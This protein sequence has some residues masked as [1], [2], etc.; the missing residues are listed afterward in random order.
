MQLLFR[1]FQ[2]HRL[3]LLSLI[4]LTASIARGQTTGSLADEIHKL[5]A[6]RKLGQMRVGVQVVCLQD[7]PL[8]ICE[9][10]ADQPFKPASNQKL[11]TTSAAMALLPEDFKF[12]T[13]LAHRGDDLVVIGS[14]D[15]AIGDPKLAR[16]AHE[17]ITALFH[18]WADKIRSAGISRITG[19]LVFDDFIFEQEHI[20]PSWEQQFQS[21]MQRWYVAPV[22]GLN[23]NDNCVDVL[24]RPG[25]SIGAD[26]EVTLI[27]NTPYIQLS[28]SCKTAEKGEPL[29]RRTLNDTV[30]VIVSR[31]IAKS[32]NP[33]SPISLTVGDPGL[34]FAST[35][36]TVL[37][38]KGI[39][40]DGE[41]RRERVRL[42]DGSIP[43][44]L[45]IIARHEQTLPDLFLRSNR[46]SQNLF[47]E[48]LLKAVGAYVGADATARLGSYDN[49]QKVV[50][51]FL[52][53]LALSDEGCVID[54]GSGLSHSNRVTPAVLTGLL[55][56]MDRHP[57]RDEWLSN[58]ATPGGEGT[59]RRRLKELNGMMFAKT[60]HISGVSTL[61]G[62][63]YG[64]DNRRYAF[65]VLCNDTN[66][67][68]GMSAHAIQ[69]AI[70]RKLATWDGPLS[71]RR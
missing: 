30:N 36:R 61:T 33:T 43:D 23:F 71:A 65:S 63:V 32:S 7:R 70:C 44:D 58:L 35:L 17:P 57:R 1:C 38:A 28:N 22:G 68:A 19:D 37:A 40:T 15:P 21:Q 41:L 48:A 16:A 34:F 60:G 56:Y 12:T 62:Y 31:S 8:L 51:L 14:G 6:S 39:A 45:D 49:G 66:K 69:N 53:K 5:L 18:E 9:Q 10:H 42:P 50:K 11:I 47:A 3:I 24:V 64:P 59:L 25:A 52:K 55:I 27:P 29:I 2:S 67:A 54:D 4:L 20:H 46:D 13:L 26:A